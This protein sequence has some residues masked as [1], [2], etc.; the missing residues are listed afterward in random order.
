MKKNIYLIGFMGAGKS[1]VARILS[2]RCGKTLI[3]MDEE[4]ERQEGKTIRE[5]F[6]EHGEAYFRARETSFLE[7]L[8]GQRNLVVSCGGG[9]P[10]RPCNVEAM[11]RG[12]QIVYLSTRPETIYE[13]VKD[14]HTRP[15]LEDHMNVD[16]IRGLLEQRLPAY[17][18]AAD[19]TVGT[20][21]KT[22]EE[23]A[24]EILE[25]VSGTP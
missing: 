15:L 21:G 12:G 1:T 7:S 9:A 6:A 24:R 20:D 17:Q 25:A 22:S 4:I 19:W 16:D 5:I 14:A 8:E 10:M 3:E 13:R 18:A 11:R 2:S 23:V